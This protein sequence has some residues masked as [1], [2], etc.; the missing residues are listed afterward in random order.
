MKIHITYGRSATGTEKLLRQ[1]EERSN[2]AT[3]KL[4]P[5]V[6]R[7]LRSIRRDGDTGLRRYAN[8]FDGLTSATP[9]RV[10]REEMTAAWRDTP[11]ELRYSMQLAA[12]NI[13]RFARWQLPK[14][15][16]RTAQAD[17][18]QTG[19]QLGQH[20]VPLASVGCY[21][22][23]GRYPLPS[24]LL[25]TVLPAQVAGVERIVVVS[26]RPAKETLAAAYLAGVEEFYRIGGAQAIAALAYGTATIPRVDKIVGPGNLYVTTA[27]KLVAFDCGIDM[28]AGPTEIVIASENGDPVFLAADLVAQAEHDPNALAIFV[29]SNRS[30]AEA[31]AAQVAKQSASNAI[32]RQSLRKNGCIF[33]TASAK[34]TAA[35]TNRLAPEHLTIDSVRDLLWVRHAG[36]VFIGSGTPQS[37][38]DYISGPNHVLPTGRVARTRAGLSVFDYLRLITTQSYTAQGL[39][40]LGPHTIRLAEAEGLR[41]HAASVRIRLQKSRKEIKAK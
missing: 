19:L 32:A 29:T 33:L 11:L 6:R 4:E 31:I 22:P 7:I 13:R 41:G 14:S 1:L 23:G 9:L 30:L 39:A 24:T 2:I 37:M 5:T 27:K 8:K 18:L 28:L 34:E 35:V 36:S 40:A 3:E 16:T 25:M 38:G 12:K 10:T 20:C 21:V 17:P 26:P 15:W